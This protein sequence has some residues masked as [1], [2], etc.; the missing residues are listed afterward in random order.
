MDGMKVGIV[1]CGGISSAHRKGR[2]ADCHVPAY[3]KASA[4]KLH[5]LLEDLP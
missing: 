1:G 3:A 5:P 2:S 4:G